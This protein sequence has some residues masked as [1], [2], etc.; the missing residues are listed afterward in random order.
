MLYLRAEGFERKERFQYIRQTRKS[1]IWSEEDDELYTLP[2][3][4]VPLVYSVHYGQQCSPEWVD[5][6]LTA[7]TAHRQKKDELGKSNLYVEE[8]FQQKIETR[9]LHP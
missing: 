8:D 5:S 1:S 9:N 2:D 3:A 7:K 4:Q 6:S